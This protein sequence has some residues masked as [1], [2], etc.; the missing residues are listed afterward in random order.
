MLRSISRKA[1]E[2]MRANVMTLKPLPTKSTLLRRI[3][4]IKCAPGL[5]HEMFAL[6]KL[7]LSTDEFWSKQCVLMF[8]EMQLKEKFDYC[9]RLKIMFTNHKKI[10]VA[11]IR[12]VVKKLV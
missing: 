10:Q 12:K 9:H 1:Y 11:I 8:D 3:S 6:L 4:H 2:L 7:K 5:Q